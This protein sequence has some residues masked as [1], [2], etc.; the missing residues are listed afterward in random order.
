M[1]VESKRPKV[2]VE[3]VTIVDNPEE[4]ARRVLRIL[5]SPGVR[6]RYHACDT[7]AIKIGTPRVI[8]NLHKNTINSRRFIFILIYLFIYNFFI[9]MK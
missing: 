5:M 1:A 8:D 9:I 2:S 6:E 7:E 4:E 3:G